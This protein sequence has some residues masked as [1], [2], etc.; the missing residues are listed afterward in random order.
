[1]TRRGVIQGVGHG[2][3]LT[4]PGAIGSHPNPT[5]LPLLSHSWE[6]VLNNLL[7]PSPLLTYQYHSGDTFFNL[8]HRRDTRFCSMYKICTKSINFSLKAA[9]TAELCP[10]LPQN[11]TSLSSQRRRSL[12]TRRQT[13]AHCAL[14]QRVSIVFFLAFACR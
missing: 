13:H 5:C 2:N 6:T 10:S 12:I 9:S 4:G 14:D 8:F 3:A 11:Q 7:F 1:M